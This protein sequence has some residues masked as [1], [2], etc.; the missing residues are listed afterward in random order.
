MDLLRWISLAVAVLYVII[1]GLGA[2]S[3]DSSK[4]LSSQDIF[5]GIG[6]I[7]LW[8]AISLGCIWWG[9]DLGEGMVGAKFGLISSA[10]PGWA[11][12][13]MGWVL[14]LLPGALFLIWGLG[15]DGGV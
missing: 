11:V 8:L 5:E 1:L 2:L 4:P 9:D 6:G 7:G 13:L 14:L 10:S 15:E 12:K 3:D